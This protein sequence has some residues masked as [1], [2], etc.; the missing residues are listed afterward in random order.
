MLL[1][2]GRL[3]HARV[4]EDDGCIIVTVGHLVDHDAIEHAGVQVFVLHVDVALGDA[5]VENALGN[6][7]LR[8]LLLHR[9]KQPGHLLL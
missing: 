5:V 2:G 1:L 7:Q 6:L 3:K 8:T 9:D 4:G